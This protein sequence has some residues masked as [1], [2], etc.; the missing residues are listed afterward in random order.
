MRQARSGCH[1]HVFPVLVSAL[2]SA[3]CL[4]VW[5]LGLTC[6]LPVHISEHIALMRHG[7]EFQLDAH[8]CFRVWPPN[9]AEAIMRI[10]CGT[11]NEHK[12]PTLDQDKNKNVHE[13]V[14]YDRR[15]PT[16]QHPKHLCCKTKTNN[17]FL[18]KLVMTLQQFW[19]SGARITNFEYGRRT[20]RS[21]RPKQTW[22]HKQNILLQ[23][24]K[25]LCL[26]CLQLR[27]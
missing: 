19:P 1:C 27:L 17:H 2:E 12:P 23:L 10:T 6:T 11:I 5:S 21:P 13:A 26:M 25:V 7:Q 9:T 14:A 15:T 3:V 22:R 24:I 16:E 4:T 18:K 8:T 20:Q